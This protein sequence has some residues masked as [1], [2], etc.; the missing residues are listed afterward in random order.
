MKNLHI[1]QLLPSS[2]HSLFPPLS[3]F[4]PSFSSLLPIITSP[5]YS[6]SLPRA[7]ARVRGGGEIIFLFLLSHSLSLSPSHC[8]LFP[9][10]RKFPS[11]NPLCISVPSPLHAS[12]SIPPIPPFL[13]HV[14]QPLF[15][16]RAHATKKFP[17]F[18][19]LNRAFFSHCLGEM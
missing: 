14:S 13:L 5:F 7:H 11:Y 2:S 10:Q 3:F 6:F 19:L 12:L 17:S 18:P 8:P 1:L 9:V 4:S 15:L 16:S